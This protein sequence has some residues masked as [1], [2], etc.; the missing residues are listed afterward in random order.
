M[1]APLPQMLKARLHPLAKGRYSVLF[2][3]KLLVEGSRDPECDAARALLAQGITGKLTLC[4]GKTGRPRTII[5]IEK[6]AKL[7]VEE[8][9]HGPH[10]VKA[11]TVVDRPYS[12]ETVELVSDSR[13]VA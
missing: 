6:A 1:K 4:D 10:F 7:T 9:P 11:R 12:P 5:D 13:E 2:D 3:G 8:G